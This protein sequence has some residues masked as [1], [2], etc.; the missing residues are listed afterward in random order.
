MK[1]LSKRRHD[2]N[3]TKTR[4]EHFSTEI[5]FEIFDYLTGN[6]IYKSFFGL[7]RRFNELI[8][9]TANIHL[10]LSR[11]T[12]KFHRKIDRIFPKKNIA[13]ISILYKNAQLLKTLFNPIDGCRLRS[14]SIL[15]VPLCGFEMSIPET[16]NTFKY[17]LNRLEI[18]FSDMC[19]T[20]TGARAAQSFAYLLTE[21]PVLKNLALNYREG[22]D[23]ITYMSSAV[24]NNTITNLTLTLY[25]ANRLAPLLYRFEQLIILNIHFPKNIL[26]RGLMRREATEYYRNSLSEKTSTGYPMKI[27]H[28]NIYNCFMLL[29]RVDQLFKFISS[30]SL[31]TVNLFNC[32]LPVARSP[33]RR[34]ELPF[35]DGTHWHDLLAKYFSS[36]V[37]LKLLHIEY[38]YVG[39]T[40]S[41]TSLAHVNEKL[42]NYNRL[43]SSWSIHCSYNQEKNLLVFG[44]L[45]A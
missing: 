3:L 37:K 27:R 24:I 18:D 8:C 1:K 39:A 41:V 19:Y 21:L 7:N 11:T 9:N 32:K 30:P 13:S 36:S 44:F 12:T 43:A 10:N 4:F 16:L 2:Q 38:P 31:V 23:P 40:M 33:M 45:S 25:D 28:I 17:Q 14:F 6:E 22:I 5:F 35:I 34:Q 26:K 29:D 15:N 20:G 42:M